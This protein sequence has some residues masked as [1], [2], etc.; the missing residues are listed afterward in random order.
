MSNIFNEYYIVN[1][2]YN[3]VDFV[4]SYDDERDFDITSGCTLSSF[5]PVNFSCLE[6][7]TRKERT[8]NIDVYVSC[9]ILFSK[10]YISAFGK[11][12]LYKTSLLPASIN[13][14][15]GYFYLHCENHI[16]ILKGDKMDFSILADIPLHKR[17][18]FRPSEDAMIYLFHASLVEEIGKVGHLKYSNVIP[19]GDSSI[20]RML[21]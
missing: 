17:T 14:E 2:K 15:I 1:K 18:L 16:D 20:E 12:P 11:C 3:N 13:N 9:E 5:F 7:P 10:E 4:I 19:V 8:E 6:F 21:S